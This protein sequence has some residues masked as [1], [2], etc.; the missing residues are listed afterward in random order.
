MLNVCYNSVSRF[1][2]LVGVSAMII[3]GNCG[4]PWCDFFYT[5]PNFVDLAHYE[6]LVSAV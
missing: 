3:F 2:P 4:Q 5:L 1:T 6:K